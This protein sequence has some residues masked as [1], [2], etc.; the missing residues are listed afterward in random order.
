MS[1]SE[2]VLI[3]VQQH[4][5]MLLL[6]LPTQES[7]KVRQQQF[8]GQR[9]RGGSTPVKYRLNTG[10]ARLDWKWASQRAK[11]PMSEVPN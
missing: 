11:I 6:M 7:I 9:G 3:I 8:V 1:K 2:D 10:Q 5:K 4:V